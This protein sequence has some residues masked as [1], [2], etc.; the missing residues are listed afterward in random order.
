M[1][2]APPQPA[3][4]LTLCSS[5]CAAVATGAIVAAA[6]TALGAVCRLWVETQLTLAPQEALIVFEQMA[7]TTTLQPDDAM[8]MQI[9]AIVGGIDSSSELSPIAL[10]VRE[11]LVGPAVVEL[12][13]DAVDGVS[14]TATLPAGFSS[15]A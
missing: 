3:A 12:V 11:V 4:A 2:S 15:A 5:H 13:A 10:R 14:R 1:R 9:G 8:R 6:R 7:R